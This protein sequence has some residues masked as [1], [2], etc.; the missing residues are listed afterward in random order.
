MQER[1]RKAKPDYEK[2]K[3]LDV[4]DPHNAGTIVDLLSRFNGLRLPIVAIAIVTVVG[5]IRAEVL[6]WVQISS[7]AIIAVLGLIEHLSKRRE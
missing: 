3:G 7:I 1:K 4:H 5:F 2:F 6:P